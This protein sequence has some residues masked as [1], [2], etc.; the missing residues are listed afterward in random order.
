ML[1][2]AAARDR[3][4]S[5]SLA[6]TSER[7][8]ELKQR[9]PC[10]EELIERL[11]QTITSSGSSGSPLFVFG[12]PGTGKTA[13]VR[14]AQAVSCSIGRQAHCLQGRGAPVARNQPAERMRSRACINGRASVQGRLPG[15]SRASCVRQLPGSQPDQAAAQLG[16]APAQG[17]NIHRPSVDLLERTRPAYAYGRHGI[18][19]LNADPSSATAEQGAKRRR[20]EG[21]DCTVQ[22]DSI[23]DFLQLLPG[24]RAARC[25]EDYIARGAL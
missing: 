16:A 13:I 7:V 9:W 18:C 11:A 22:C 20:D 5:G 1:P 6:S 24:G 23:T 21:Y 25:V 17:V 19:T 10:R 8:G 14:W 3:I 12:P 15:G 2:S 4:A